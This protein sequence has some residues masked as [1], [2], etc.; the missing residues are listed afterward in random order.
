LQILGQ[1]CEFQVEEFRLDPNDPDG[2]GFTKAQFVASRGGTAE[3]DAAVRCIYFEPEGVCHAALEFPGDAETETRGMG[4]ADPP[5]FNEAPPAQPA[6]AQL[7]GPIPEF[8]SAE[9]RPVRQTDGD[10]DGSIT[11]AAAPAPGVSNHHSS[12]DHPTSPYSRPRRS[13]GPSE[14]L[15]I[16]YE[17]VAGLRGRL[18]GIVAALDAD[19]D[20]ALSGTEVAAA[21]ATVR[22]RPARPGPP[23]QASLRI[24]GQP[25]CEFQVAGGP[26]VALSARRGGVRVRARGD[27]RVARRR[28]RRP[29]A[30]CSGR[31]VHATRRRRASNDGGGPARQ[32]RPTR[33]LC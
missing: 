9:P 30:S 20:A 17:D 16:D 23:R 33:A 6:A 24:L 10:G 29:T 11:Y 31:C 27:R 13:C 22:P 2:G 25:V 15:L 28:W 26:R 1:P 3:W 4:S 21:V 12:R 5:R 7:M 19:A 32:L 8:A 18:R 14:E